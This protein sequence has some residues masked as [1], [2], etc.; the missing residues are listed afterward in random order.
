MAKS[1]SL[2]LSAKGLPVTRWFS[3]RGSVVE[4]GTS[5]EVFVGG[6]LI[7][8]FEPDEPL[9]RNAI[10]V[11]LAEDPNCHLGRLADAFEISSERLR[12]L[13]REYENG[14]LEALQPGEP[15]GP[16][17]LNARDLVRLE[18]M[19]AD[20]LRPQA[21]QQKFKRASMSTVQ[22]A[23]RVWRDARASKPT[24]TLVASGSAE[25]RTLSLPG[26]EMLPSSAGSIEA[27]PAGAPTAGAATA[28]DLQGAASVQH[29]G[30][31]LL[32]AMV[33]RLGLYKTAEV[34]SPGRAPF[35]L[36]RVGFDATIAALAI[37]EH[38]LEGVRRLRTPTAKLLLRA[39]TV[40][41]PDALRALMDNLSADLGAVGMHVSMLRSYV[42]GD[43]ALASDE[44]GV[45]YVDNH[46]RP[47]TGKHVIRKGWRM[48]DKHVRP[49]VT[50]YYVHDEDGRPLFRID[51]ASHDSLPIWLMP[52]VNQLRA[53]VGDDD[54]LL[55]AFDRG[56]AFPET[57][58][59][60]RDEG[61]EFVTYERAPYPVLPESAF[62]S[63]VTFDEDDADETETLRFVE[64]RINLK[65][66]RGRVRRLAVRDEDGRQ[67]NLL[68]SSTRSAERLIGIM[69]GRWIQ[70][71]GFKHGNERWGINHLDARRVVP[72]DPDRIMPNPARRRL[73]VARRAASVREGD[74]RNV[75][76]RYAVEHP[77]H[78]RA[79]RIIQA[80]IED[81]RAIDEL[82]PFVPK[83][84]RVGDTELA[85]KLVQHDGRRKLLVDT[86]RIACANAESDLAILLARYMTKPR[87]AKK[88][89]AN[90]LRSPGRLRVNQTSITIEVAPA[91]TRTEAKAIDSFLRVVSRLGLT[92]PGDDRG[93]KLRFR[94]QVH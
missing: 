20:G 91:S 76:A 25:E 64:S 44:P 38:S 41:T 32:V 55:V 92:L 69:R 61:V 66:G 43:R 72:V 85:G 7:G 29:L 3:S 10:L 15:G 89:L 79:L 14:G 78:Q 42:E 40:P 53:V 26:V 54:H 31:W 51:V 11:Q 70:E 6:T 94:S 17:R 59:T 1:E 56:G 84:A 28:D 74:A 37:G 13:R 50:D 86:I 23:F 8:C 47:Y 83:H 9:K 75:L 24:E 2:P 21:A 88:L 48:Q 39:V 16:R 71:N 5:T 87:E 62:T 33:A 67:I 18:R 49:G 34:I 52:I 22:R 45:F 90:I 77:K 73:D 68:A 65:K 60:L 93:R 4:R 19:F 80:A 57:M 58:A 81:E 36:V 30:T 35:E 27:P 12:Q 46:M 63:E 82:R